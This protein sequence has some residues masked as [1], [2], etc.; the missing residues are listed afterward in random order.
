MSAPIIIIGGATAGGKS[1]AALAIAQDEIGGIHQHVSVRFGGDSE[2]EQ[3]GFPM[4]NRLRLRMTA[5]RTDLPV[6]DGIF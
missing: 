1:A 4:G 6:L 2:S 5:E 3:D